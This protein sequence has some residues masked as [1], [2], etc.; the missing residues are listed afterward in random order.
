MLG[1]KDVRLGIGPDGDPLWGDSVVYRLAMA[2]REIKELD[3]ERKSRK[4]GSE[5]MAKIDEQ[6]AEK[7]RIL[8]SLE[9]E[10]AGYR[11]DLPV[12]QEELTRQQT[13]NETDKE[14]FT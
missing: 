8:K 13:A 12:L 5:Q 11:R 10:E 1:G 2:R 9:I 7:R 6:L 3:E 4:E 14:L